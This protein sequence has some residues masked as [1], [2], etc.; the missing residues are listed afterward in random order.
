MT[1]KSRPPRS[2]SVAGRRATR[3]W[4]AAPRPFSTTVRTGS[5]RLPP[6]M[7][8]AG[9]SGEAARAGRAPLAYTSSKWER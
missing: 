3:L 7:P 6:A 4:R 9:M 5:R 1:S 8:S 2:G